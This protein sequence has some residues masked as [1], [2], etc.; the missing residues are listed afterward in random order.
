MKTDNKPKRVSTWS[1]W[2]RRHGCSAA[3]RKLQA[4]GRVICPNC[5]GGGRN[6]RIVP[7]PKKY[8]TCRRCHGR[9]LVKRTVSAEVM[10]QLHRAYG[11][12]SFNEKWVAQDWPDPFTGG[13][14]PS[15]QDLKFFTVQKPAPDPE[16]LL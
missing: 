8:V 12:E 10:A 2:M 15:K 4:S 7:E 9:G 11:A 16:K 5:Y 13:G 6:Y 1:I 14:V 3:I